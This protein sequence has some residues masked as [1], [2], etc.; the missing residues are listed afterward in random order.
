MYLNCV[1]RFPLRSAASRHQSSSNCPNIVFVFVCEE[2]LSR[3][4]AHIKYTQFV[5]L[6]VAVL[7]VEEL[8]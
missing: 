5:Y 7:S 6:N 2:L 3:T 1:R 4:Q 8:H